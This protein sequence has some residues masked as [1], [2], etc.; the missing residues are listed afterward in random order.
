MENFNNA[1]MF[2]LLATQQVNIWS[3][4]TSPVATLIYIAALILAI[5]ILVLA[6]VRDN[7]KDSFLDA[8]RQ[9]L[10][11]TN[12]EDGSESRFYMLTQVDKEMAKAPTKSYEDDI[13]MEELCE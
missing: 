7:K 12:D 11:L 9:D 5:A 1:N 2:P 13:T 4:L 6:I 8:S 10:S 3:A